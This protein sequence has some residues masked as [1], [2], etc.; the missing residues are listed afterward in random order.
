MI[1][2]IFTFALLV[3]LITSCGNT[4]KKD[5]TAKAIKVEGIEIVNFDSLVAHTDNYIGKKIMVE[6]KVVHVCRESGKKLFIVGTNPDIR[7]YIQAGENMSKFPLELLGSEV[8]VEGTI[9]KVGGE[10]AMGEDKHKAEGEKVKEG[11]LCET[12]T[13]LA[14]QTSLTDVVMAYNSHSV[15]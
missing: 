12:E 7:L 15:K 11:E 5:E 4:T 10:I 1:K 13:A 2:R 3:A 6:G 9:S 8:M 14:A